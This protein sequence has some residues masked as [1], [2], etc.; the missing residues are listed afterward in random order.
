MPTSLVNINAKFLNKILINWDRE[1]C[2]NINLDEVEFVPRMQGRCEALWH[3]CHSAAR[4]CVPSLRPWVGSACCDHHVDREWQ[5]VSFLSLKGHQLPQLVS[6][7]VCFEHGL[8][9]RGKRSSAPSGGHTWRRRAPRGSQSPKHEH[10]GAR[11]VGGAIVDSPGQ[12]THS[13]NATKW[14]LND[15]WNRRISH[16]APRPKFPTHTIR[17]Y[18]EII[19][20]LCDLFWRHLWWGDRWPGRVIEE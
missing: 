9:C 6:W 15:T 13:M 4:M 1:G 3:S 2:K 20:V 18:K 11:R 10:W 17:R 19:I 14:P 12:A 7:D 8:S 5:C 16:W